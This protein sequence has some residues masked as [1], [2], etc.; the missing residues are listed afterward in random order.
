MFELLLGFSKDV[1]GA[2]S[3][4]TG[5]SIPRGIGA[6]PN[7][8][9]RV[10]VRP[11]GCR[12]WPVEL[13]VAKNELALGRCEDAHEHRV[14]EDVF[15]RVRTILWRWNVETQRA[16]RGPYW[17]TD[18]GY[19]IGDTES[20]PDSPL[21]L[22]HPDDHDRIREAVESLLVGNTDATDAEFRILTNTSEGRWVHTSTLVSRTDPTGRPIELT[23]ILLDIHERKLAEE[24]L[25]VQSE[26]FE[27]ILETI[28][29]CILITD[30]RMAISSY[31]NATR[32]MLGYDEG[33]IDGIP[34][35]ELVAET[36][37]RDPIMW[38]PPGVRVLVQMTHHI[39]KLVCLCITLSF[40]LF[41]RIAW[42]YFHEQET[43]HLIS[44]FLGDVCRGHVSA[45]GC[46]SAQCR[47]GR[48]EHNGDRDA[49]CGVVRT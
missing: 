49:N 40:R 12:S 23:G 6:P 16:E 27:K 29:H 10:S 31:N 47:C 2:Q 4:Y 38:S 35:Y 24:A 45:L 20:A 7:A 18:L 11:I 19:Q 3:V 43:G 17:T 9:L 33:E 5:L 8:T 30:G 37:T 21:K 28:S 14:I 25:R 26:R 1:L 48:R 44:L 36:C 13:D 22:V 32:L 39:F 41:D 15:D 42:W 34:Y 46:C